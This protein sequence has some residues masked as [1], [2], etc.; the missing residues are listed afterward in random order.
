MQMHQRLEAERGTLIGEPFQDGMILPLLPA[1]RVSSCAGVV[2][3]EPLLYQR[4]LI[5][6][7]LLGTL[8]KL[9]IMQ[10]QN[11][12]QFQSELLLLHF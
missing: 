3:P 7:L 11:W 12:L 6:D 4:L 10:R 1:R 2:F 9:I 8:T 5:R